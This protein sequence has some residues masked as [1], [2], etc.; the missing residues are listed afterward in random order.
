MDLK[1]IE[2]VEQPCRFSRL[3]WQGRNLVIDV[4][5]NEQG[6]T[7]VLNELKRT[8]PGDI[9]VVCGFGVNKDVEPIFRLLK[10]ENMISAVFP[11]SSN[12]FRLQ[13]AH[14]LFRVM[15]KF[16]S[17]KFKSPISLP[18]TLN[19]ILSTTSAETTV[20]I[21]GSF[22]IMKDVYSFLGIPVEADP[23]SANQVEPV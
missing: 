22:F 7:S 15:N 10:A 2:N 23:D 20:L 9:V 6:V 12:H 14:D 13:S 8:V 17:G 5:H 11:I 19:K 16:G 1:S 4:A 21:M 18:E 3:K